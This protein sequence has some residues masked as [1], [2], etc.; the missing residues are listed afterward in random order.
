MLAEFDAQSGTLHQE[1]LDD[2]RDWID[3]VDTLA[4]QAQ[5]RGDLRP[6]ADIPQLT[7]ELTAALEH[8]NYY[9]VLFDDPT[10]ISRARNAVQAAITRAGEQAART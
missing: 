5:A 4:H 1:V 3:L 7:F 8:A 9:S 2:Q 6:D 10:V